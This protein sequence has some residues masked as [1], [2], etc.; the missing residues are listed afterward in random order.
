M[1][2]TSNYMHQRYSLEWV[3][4]RVFLSVNAARHSYVAF[5]IKNTK[6][7]VCMYTCKVYMSLVKS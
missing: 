4:V 3:L 1:Y 2:I 5:H 7:R 6:E